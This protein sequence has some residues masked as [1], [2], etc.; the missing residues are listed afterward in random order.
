MKLDQTLFQ[1]YSQ[2]HLNNV[3]KNDA[4]NNSYKLIEELRKKY[5]K[6]ILK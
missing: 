6:L 3:E 5:E 2:K 1:R 4:Y